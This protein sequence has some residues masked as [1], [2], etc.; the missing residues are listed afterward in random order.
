MSRLNDISIRVEPPEKA[1]SNLA[2]ATAVLREV[3]RL[4][5][6]FLATGEP[7][8][9][10]LRAQPHMEPA[11]YRRLRHAL[12][13]GEVTALVD[14]DIKVEVTETQYSGVWWLTHRNAD[15]EIVTEVIDITLIPDILRTHV[16]EIR[17]G[18]K[19]LD[20]AL[21]ASTA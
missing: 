16:A 18:L 17:A 14:A 6:R 11:T 10:D 15:D 13:A 2:V 5:A 19:R 21:S 3:Q 20:Q 8:S 4:L 9:I 12:M 7:G 1:T